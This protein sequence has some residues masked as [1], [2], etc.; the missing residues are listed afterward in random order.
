M[1]LWDLR[2]LCGGSNDYDMIL[3]LNL[4]S[5]T[6]FLELILWHFIKKVDA[7][8]HKM[9]NLEFQNFRHIFVKSALFFLYLWLSV[10]VDITLLTFGGIG[11]RVL[12]KPIL[13]WKIMWYKYKK[14]T[15]FYFSQC[16]NIFPICWKILEIFPALSVSYPDSFVLLNW[17]GHP[18]HLAQIF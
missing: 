14:I 10:W 7:I 18:K 4:I 12:A 16:K 8:L 1:L 13:R 6:L 3:V 15:K 5:C 9:L 17:H 2:T 11:V